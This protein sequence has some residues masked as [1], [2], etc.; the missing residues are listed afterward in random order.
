MPDQTGLLQS[1]RG[2]RDTDEQSLRADGVV[3]F[4]HR[5]TRQLTALNTP[6][7]HTQ[8]TKS[9]AQRSSGYLFLEPQLVLL[10][11]VVCAVCVCVCVWGVVLSPTTSGAS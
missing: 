5:K 10:G 1:G 7:A 4:R 6:T 3:G 2:A 11:G 8:A 9:K